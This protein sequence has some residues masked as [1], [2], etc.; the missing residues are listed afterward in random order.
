MYSFVY[1]LGRFTDTKVCVVHRRQYFERAFLWPEREL[2]CCPS[3]GNFFHAQ[4]DSGD[5]FFRTETRRCRWISRFFALAACY[6]KA[7][8]QAVMPRFTR[9]GP[10]QPNNLLRTKLVT[11][12][13]TTGQKK[14]I[15]KSS[16]F[17]YFAK[18]SSLRVQ[19]RPSRRCKEVES[20][21]NV[22]SQDFVIR[23]SKAFLLGRG[24]PRPDYET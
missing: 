5:L 13:A 16:F 20:A 21:A 2:V 15:L 9:G 7:A 8:E 12:S 18:K 24:M 11:G 10:T 4:E 19:A 14:F 23:R 6:V 1:L 22:S 3:G 17:C